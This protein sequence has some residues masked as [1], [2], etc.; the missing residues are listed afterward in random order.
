MVL[1]LLPFGLGSSLPSCRSH[2]TCVGPR[3]TTSQA[4]STDPE[5]EEEEE[6]EERLRFWRDGPRIRGSAMSSERG[7]GNM[8]SYG[9]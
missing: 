3:L 7:R 9:L 8:I 2:C 6:D 1:F 5:E 4:S